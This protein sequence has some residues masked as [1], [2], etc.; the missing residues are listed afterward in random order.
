VQA[1]LGSGASAG[2]VDS[3]YGNGKTLAFGFDW[4]TTLNTQA[5]NKAWPA[6]AQASMNYVEP[7]AASS[8]QFIAGD[9]IT[10]ATSVQNTG[11]A[12]NL[13]VVQ[14]LPAGATVASTS[15]VAQVGGNS[16]TWTA[17]LPQGA[18]QVFALRLQAP[19]AAGSYAVGT[20]VNVVSNGKATPYQSENFAFTV[21]GAS[22]L[23]T[24]LI[25]AVQTHNT[26]SA[27]QQAV[28]TAVLTQLGTAQSALSASHSQDE[29]LRLLLSAQSRL[30]AIDSGGTLEP[31]LANL[32]AAVERQTAP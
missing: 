2:I 26:G 24:Q 6:I 9:S 5:S 10:L 19:I 11:Q 4:A 32:I 21:Q 31:L 18:S 27:Q 17:A 29:V 1:T 13:Q 12:A 22:D 28:A 23:M 7:A 30:A 16:V 8:T 14:T 3:V 15:P 20:S 25:A